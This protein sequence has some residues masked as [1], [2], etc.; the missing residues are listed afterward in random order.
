MIDFTLE[1]T[2]AWW[3]QVVSD[4]SRL[5]KWLQKLYRTE[6]EGYTDHMY[7][8][9]KQ[10]AIKERDA[11]ILTNVALDELKHSH[12]LSNVMA[13]RGIP[14]GTPPASSYWA[15]MNSHVETF[16][17]YCAINHYGEGL[18]AFRFEVIFQMPETPSDIREAIDIILP[19][20]QFHRVTLKN[21]AGPEALAKLADIHQKAVSSLKR[22]A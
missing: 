20:E 14:L 15:E 7:Y 16:E 1:E 3:R 19:D 9:S 13:C 8:L 6:L 2:R 12:I 11:K 4:E 21:L 10:G 18:A 5:A 22:V 17:D